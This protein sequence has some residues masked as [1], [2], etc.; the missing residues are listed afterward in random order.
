TAECKVSPA[1]SVTIEKHC[2]ASKGGATLVDA[3]SAVEVKV[4]YTAKVCNTGTSQL[5]GVGLADDWGNPVQHDSLSSI[6]SLA[7]GACTTVTASYVP[8]SIDSST[9]R[10]GFTDTV[11]VTSATATLGP[12]PTPASACPA[13]SDLACAPVTCPICFDSVCTGLPQP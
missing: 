1:S 9:G 2:D 4:F 11:R 8:N 13:S 10:Y 12:N 7:P 5:T 6:A 3:G